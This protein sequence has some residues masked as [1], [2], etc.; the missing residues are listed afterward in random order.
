MITGRSA[1]TRRCRDVLRFIDDEAAIGEPV[2][3]E[4]LGLCSTQFRKHVRLLEE[5]GF[6]T[7]NDG[8]LYSLSNPS[9]H[10]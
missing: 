10:A 6:I 5:R 8:V 2:L 7:R 1:L 3:R 4:R 9:A